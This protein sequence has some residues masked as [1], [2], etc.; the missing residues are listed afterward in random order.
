MSTK[1]KFL[2]ECSFDEMIKELIARGNH[3]ILTQ[4]WLKIKGIQ[5]LPDT[6]PTMIK[7]S[8]LFEAEHHT[9]K[10]KFEHIE[11]RD[12][13]KVFNSLTEY[14]IEAKRIFGR[15]DRMD[16]CDIRNEKVKRNSACVVGIC[17]REDLVDNQDGFSNLKVRPYA[18]STLLSRDMRFLSQPVSTGNFYNGFIVTRDIVATAG[19]C[20]NQE[21][22]V[23]NLR[24]VFG[25]KMRHTEVPEIRIPNENIYHGLEFIDGKYK[26]EGAD[27]AFVRL[28]REVIGQEIA[29]FP[30]EKR[31]IPDGQSVYVMGHPRGLPL[32]YA[33][34]ANVCKDGNNNPVYFEANLDTLMGNSGSPVF[35]SDT[36]EIEGI[37]VS[38]PEDYI[39]QSG[40]GYIIANGLDDCSEGGARVI[41]FTEF[42]DKINELKKE[43]ENP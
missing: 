3:R 24:F 8:T 13:Y 37:L 9:C 27:W 41:R 43:K 25:Y 32:K 5:N 15:D 30:R 26:K 33:P 31:R 22:E 42:F 1:E 21:T 2:K 35:N 4:E 23:K 40:S 38:T 36:H 6:D 14:V 19:H 39:Y 28:D 18:E 12:L 7:L 11:T 20:I 34:K 16:W 29:V 17:H 10:K